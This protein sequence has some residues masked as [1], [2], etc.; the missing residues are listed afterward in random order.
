MTT[1]TQIIESVY[2]IMGED[3]IISP[4]FIELINSKGLD[5]AYRDRIKSCHP[6]KSKSS[7]ISE[8]ELKENFLKVENAYKILSSYVR[9][10]KRV[11]M[12]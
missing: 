9:G 12:V 7:G 3:V 2:L 1:Y 6:D 5:R 8:V 11:V 10:N 4:E